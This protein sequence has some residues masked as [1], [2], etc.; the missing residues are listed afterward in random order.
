MNETIKTILIA[1]IVVWL[2]NNYSKEGFDYR[3]YASLPGSNN[4][5]LTDGNGNLSSIQF[6]SGM[7]M[8]WTKG[9]NNI[10][11][12]WALCDGTQGT[13]DLRGKFLL[14][15]TPTGNIPEVFRTPGQSGGSTKISVGQLPAHTHR[16]TDILVQENEEYVNRR[17]GNTLKNI[18]PSQSNWWGSS[19]PG[20]NDNEL[21]GLDDRFTFPTGAGEDYYPPFVTVAY[22][23][24]L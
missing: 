1:F 14:G 17:T 5:V 24:K 19:D 7:I 15:V 12:G 10:P 13:P 8:I 11:E 3:R 9:V 20:D 18:I 6:P 16:H 23:M 21:M 22:I 2:Y 4:M